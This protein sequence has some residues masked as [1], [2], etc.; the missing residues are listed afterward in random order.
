MKTELLQA[1]WYWGFRAELPDVPVAFLRYAGTVLSSG[2]FDIYA[3][4]WCLH[5]LEGFIDNLSAWFFNRHY[6]LN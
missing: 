2:Y 4:V 3:V 5:C 6:V 1:C